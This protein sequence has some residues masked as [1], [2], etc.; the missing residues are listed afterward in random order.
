MINDPVLYT[1]GI[2]EAAREP[3]TERRGDN[4][5]RGLCLSK[6]HRSPILSWIP[7]TLEVTVA[8]AAHKHPNLAGGTL[9]PEAVRQRILVT[10][11]NVS[12][13][14]PNGIG[15]KFPEEFRR[16]IL[17][18]VERLDLSPS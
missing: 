10:I 12:L 6:H 7:A 5:R 15:R 18:A 1:A 14:G 13:W 9:D 11:S 16:D 8:K 2:I 17:N 3:D 4:G